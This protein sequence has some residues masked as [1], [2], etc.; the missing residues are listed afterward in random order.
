MNFFPENEIAKTH[1][2]VNE[3]SS[4]LARSYFRVARPEEVRTTKHTPFQ[5]DSIR[6]ACPLAKYRVINDQV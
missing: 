1:P 4:A 3:F 5:A 2:S 6:L